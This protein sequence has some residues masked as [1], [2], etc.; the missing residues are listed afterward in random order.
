MIDFVID[1]DEDGNCYGKYRRSESNI[2]DDWE[3]IVEV[4]DL[5][6]YHVTEWRYDQ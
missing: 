6:D 4:E 5:S 3:D 1:P 2:P